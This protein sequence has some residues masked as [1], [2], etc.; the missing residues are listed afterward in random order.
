M[1]YVRKSRMPRNSAAG[2]KRRYRKVRPTKRPATYAQ[3]SRVIVGRS[4]QAVGFPARMFT[5]IKLGNITLGAATTTTPDGTIFRLNDITDSDLTS[6]GAAVRPRYYNQLGNLYENYRVHGCKIRLDVFGQ[7]PLTASKVW[8][9]P[10]PWGVTIDGTV[11]NFDERGYPSMI[12]PPLAQAKVMKRYFSCPRVEGL[13]KLKY[14]MDEDY[15]GK[16]KRRTRYATFTRL[17]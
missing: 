8:M 4:N 15:C 5:K 12:I 7:T 1:P 9:V 3:H 14:N 10:V 16:R 11:E 13:S 2:K 17:L 6:T